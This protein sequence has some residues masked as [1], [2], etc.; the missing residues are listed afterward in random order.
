MPV[1]TFPLGMG[2]LCAYLYCFGEEELGAPREGVEAVDVMFKGKM[3][4]VIFGR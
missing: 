3:S 2:R 1:C 4:V